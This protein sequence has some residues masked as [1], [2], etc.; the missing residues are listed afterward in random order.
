MDIISYD[1]GPSQLEENN[2]KLFPAQATGRKPKISSRSQSNEEKKEER[3]KNERKSKQS[4]R[5]VSKR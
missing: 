1:P 5:T 2:K 4:K 3:K